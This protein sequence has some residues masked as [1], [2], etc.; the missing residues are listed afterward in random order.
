MQVT[1]NM[2]QWNSHLMNPW[3][4]NFHMLYGSYV[5]LH[6]EAVLLLIWYIVYNY[7]KIISL[8]FPHYYEY[9]FHT[10]IHSYIINTIKLVSKIINDIWNEH[11]K[12]L[13]QESKKLWFHNQY[14]F[15]AC[16]MCDVNYVVTI[17]GREK[18]WT[19]T[20]FDHNCTKF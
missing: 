17:S 14:D 15:G 3:G 13:S 16:S 20:C 11:W 5:K 19:V 8:L 9:S 6:Q 10:H 1:V 2:L 7:D 12:N 18:T 4:T